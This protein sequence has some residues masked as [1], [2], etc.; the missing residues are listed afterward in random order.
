MFIRMLKLPEHKRTG[1]NLSSHEVAVHA[2]APC[3]VDVKERMIRWWGPILE[4]YYA[5]TE[6]FGS[7]SISSEEWMAHKGSVGHPSHGAVVHICDDNGTE[8]PTGEAG[9]VYFEQPTAL[10]EYHNDSGKTLRAAHPDHPAWRTLG[11]IGRL[12]EDGYLYLTDRK[13]FM[14]VSGGV[15]I[16]PQEIEDVLL[17]H[18]GVLDA[19]VIGVPNTEMGEEVKAVVQ[20]IHWDEAEGSSTDTGAETLESELR[21]WCEARLARYKRPRS[22][23]FVQSLPRLDNG[24]LYK[25]LL[26]DRYWEG[27]ETKII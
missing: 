17:A 13:A 20:P 14:I 8:L 15:N 5:G 16:Y 24:K 12:D 18:P 10:F 19:A 23:D 22:F 21:S 3:P 11:D 25:S 7:T 26:R 9:I 27:R 2:A 6:N 4:E 1:W